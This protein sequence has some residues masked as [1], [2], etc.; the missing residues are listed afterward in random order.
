MDLGT[1]CISYFPNGKQMISGSSDRTIRRWDL[2]KG[3]E[4]K[5][6]QEV[7]EYPVWSVWVSRDG[8][9]VVTAGDRHKPVLEVCEVKTGIVRRICRNGVPITVDHF[10]ISADCTLVAIA[11][12]DYD[13]TV[14]IRSLD[15][16]K[17]VAEPLECHHGYVCALRLSQDSLRL[18]VTSELMTNRGLERSYCTQ[19]WDVQAQYYLDA[20]RQFSTAAL[21]SGLHLPI[22]WTTKDK[23]IVTIF[24]LTSDDLATTICELDASTLQ[25]VGDSFKGHTST[26]RDLALSSDC[27]LLASTS[28]D[29]IIKLWSFES[30]QLL[31]SFDLQAPL[32]SFV[33]SPDSCQLAYT[34]HMEAKIYICDIPANILA[35]IGLPKEARGFLARLLNFDAPRHAVPRKPVISVI[36]PALRP[37]LSGKWWPQKGR[38]SPP[39]IEMPICPGK[40]ASVPRR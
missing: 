24:S 3:K 36:P 29:N 7:C 18:A 14:H 37:L 31:A 32:R 5:K 30:R 20:A 40:R 19:V 38:A 25:T 12:N 23:S 8:R 34:T 6:A 2:R 35:S 39:I 1:S 17:L 9:W 21:P 26:I 16:G 4:I 11:A 13:G 10:D 33:L 27:V 28:D 22:F 15:T